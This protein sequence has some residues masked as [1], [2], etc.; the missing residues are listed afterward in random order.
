M[1]T[2]SLEELENN[3]EEIP[4]HLRNRY[5]RYLLSPEW[6]K[7]KAKTHRRDGYK[8]VV[9]S[10]SKLRDTHHLTYKRVFVEKISD[11]VTLSPMHH[12][13]VHERAKKK[14]ELSNPNWPSVE[15]DF[16]NRPTGS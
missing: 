12:R 2:Y 4:R 9:C 6:R 5:D 1:K 15:Q 13:Q 3:V 7:K 14:S 10:K 11:L 8:C 16:I